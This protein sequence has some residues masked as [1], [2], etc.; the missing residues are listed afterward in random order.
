MF[1][2]F[3]DAHPPLNSCFVFG[4]MSYIEKLSFCSSELKFIASLAARMHSDDL[5]SFS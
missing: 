1:F 4:E 2:M 5:N 3:L